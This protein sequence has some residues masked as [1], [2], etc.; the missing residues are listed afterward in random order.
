MEKAQKDKRLKESKSTIPSCIELLNCFVE[1]LQGSSG[2][3]P[4]MECKVRQS[5]MLT[6]AL[7]YRMQ[8][9]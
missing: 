7:Q 2:L 5:I 3:P 9:C 6:I 8:F 1:V 4:G